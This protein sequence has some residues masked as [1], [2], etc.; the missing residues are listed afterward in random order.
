V[1]EDCG[2]AIVHE[3]AR[4]LVLFRRR[5]ARQPQLSVSLAAQASEMRVLQELQLWI[6]E[7]LQRRLSVEDL[8]GQVAM[9]VRNF[10][11]VFTREVGT[12]PAQYVL[13]I[14]VEAARRQLEHTDR[15]FK[16]IA[17]VTGFGGPTPCG[18]PSFVSSESRRSAIVLRSAR[19]QDSPLADRY[20]A[21]A[22]LKSE[23]FYAGIASGGAARKL[24][25]LGFEIVGLS[26]TDGWM[27]DYRTREAHS[28]RIC[29]GVGPNCTKCD[30]YQNL[31]FGLVTLK[32]ALNPICRKHSGHRLYRFELGRRN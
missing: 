32:R 11:R 13:H 27:R 22:R 6:A 25:Q 20:K 30:E 17:I 9:S 10:E 31:D 3:A 19:V 5:P 24:S 4:E 21:K 8:A 15:G 28:G 7:N 16:Q 1:E 18:A 2:S 23:D 29:Q 14:R 12:A 26:S